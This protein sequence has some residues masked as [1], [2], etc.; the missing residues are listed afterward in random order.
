MASSFL[1]VSQNVG[2]ALGIALL[3]TFVTNAIHR[4]AVRL[5]E[6][7]PGPSQRLDIRL[8]LRALGVVFRHESGIVAHSR[9]K[10]GFVASQAIGRRA[11]VLGFENGFV[12]AGIILL[13]A[14]PLCF[15]LQPSSHHRAI[16]KTGGLAE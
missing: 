10:I 3:N 14:I 11:A 4:H 16:G 1:N 9:D 12:L 7:L 5:G 13:M 6:I 8:G 15:L 2:G